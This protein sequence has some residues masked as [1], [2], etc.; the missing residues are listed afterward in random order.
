MGLGLRRVVLQY[1]WRGGR[2]RPESV[3]AFNRNQWQPS[4]GIGGR[5]RRESVATFD[6]NTQHSRG[7]PFEC[8]QQRL[9]V[10]EIRRIKPFGKPVIDW[11]EEVMGFLAFALL[12]PE[13][14]ETGGSTEF[15]GFGLLAAGNGEGLLEAGF[16]L[17]WLWDGLAQE[18]CT[19]EP[20][21]FRQ[22]VALAVGLQ[23]RQGFGQQ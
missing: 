2:F 20:V 7:S 18:K 13:A 17:V 1:P 9:G 11:C 12:P 10:L 14:S 22:E 8:L 23:H 6:R 15:P 4:P 5:F 3:A 19:L 21:G 16:G